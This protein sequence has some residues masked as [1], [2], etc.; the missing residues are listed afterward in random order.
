MHQLFILMWPEYF[1]QPA[2][3]ARHKVARGK[4]LCAP[5]LERHKLKPR[6]EGARW[7]EVSYRFTRSLRSSFNLRAM[8]APL[9]VAG[10]IEDLFQGRRAKPLAP[11]YLVPR[12]RR[13]LNHLSLVDTESSLFDFVNS[14]AT[15]GSRSLRTFGVGLRI[16]NYPF[17]RL[18]Y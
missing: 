11:G 13:W 1:V 4:R 6:P 16:P 12:L 9:Q 10:S 18:D 2:P 8:F 5:P 7:Q 17:F 14:F 3:K 15:R